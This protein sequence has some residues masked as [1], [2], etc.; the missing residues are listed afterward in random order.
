MKTIYLAQINNSYGNNAFLPYSMGLVWSFALTD[1]S[2]SVGYRLGGM[3]FLREDINS[4]VD[5]IRDPDVLA[6]SCY[7]WNWAYNLKLAETV[8]SR[9]PGCIIILGGPEVPNRS[10]GFFSEHGFVDILVHGEGELTMKELLA[11]LLNDEPALSSI[12]GISYRGSDDVTVKTRSRSRIGELDSIPSPYITGL[13]DD[14]VASHPTISFN[15]SQETHRGCPYSC[16]FCDWGSAVMTKVRQFGTDRLIDE[17]EWFGKN[18]IDLLYNCDANYGI[19]KRD[20][21]LTSVMISVK[22]RYEGYPSKFRAAYAKKTNDR[23][24]EIAKM[25]NDAGMN[26]GVTLS[27]QSTDANTLEN[28][29]RSNIRIDDFARLTSEYRN[30]GIPTYTEL[31]VGLPGETMASFTKGLDDVLKAGQHDNINVYMCMLLRN[32]EMS[33]PS[34][35]EKHGITSKRVP[36]LSLHGTPSQ[37]DIIEMNDIVVSTNTMPYHEWKKANVLAWMVQCMHCLGLTHFLAMDHNR[38]KGDYIGFYLGLHDRY[39]G[40]DT[41][42]GRQLGWIYDQLESVFE[43]SSNWQLIDPTYGEVSW[44][45]EEYSFLQIQKDIDA[46]YDEIADYMRSYNNHDYLDQMIDFQRNLLIKPT[47]RTDTIADYGFDLPSAY[48]DMQN[49][50]ACTIDQIKVKAMFYCDKYHGNEIE[51]AKHLVW[52]GR[53]SGKTKRTVKKLTSNNVNRR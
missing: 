13:F 16:T 5:G 34:Y 49:G 20:L 53:K 50:I 30:A 11:E 46:F 19:M 38:L 3:L 10:Q 44:P 9:Y 6:L 43:R 1:E 22:D 52:Y 28:V 35:M 31:I 24:F 26:K 37:M 45:L 40:T 21:E 36:L 32:S 41:V 18:R 4:V 51:Y 2:V 47:D 25:L 33:D 39:I 14:I 15:A 8:K 23:I 42:V 48:H 17:M 12:D 7:I 29:K 27:M